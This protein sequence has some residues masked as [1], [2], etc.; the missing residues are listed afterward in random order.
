MSGKTSG[1]V[2]RCTISVANVHCRICA[3][4]LGDV[5]RGLPGVARAT[6]GLDPGEVH[7]AFDPRITSDTELRDA[8]RSG[9]YDVARIAV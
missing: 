4:T 8:L 6:V 3:G 1:I 7:V 2:V 9:G 5:L